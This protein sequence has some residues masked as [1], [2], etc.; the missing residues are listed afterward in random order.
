MGIG[1]QFVKEI[2]SNWK[3]NIKKIE[4]LEDIADSNTEDISDFDDKNTTMRLSDRPSQ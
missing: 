2:D 1:L 4:D 3:E